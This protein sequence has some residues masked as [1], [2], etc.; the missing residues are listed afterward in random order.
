MFIGISISKL[1]AIVK[2]SNRNDNLLAF[3]ELWFFEEGKEEPTFKVKGYTIR[4]KEFGEKRVIC[5]VPPAYRA[6]FKFQTSF[7]VENKALYKDITNLFLKGFQELT[8]D[9]F[10]QSEEINLNDIPDD[11]GEKKY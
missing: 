10:T 2:L 5:V 7:I 8:G 4:E 6:G 11:L 1:E 9:V 3:G